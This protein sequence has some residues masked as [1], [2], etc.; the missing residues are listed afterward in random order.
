[1]MFRK[2][3]LYIFVFLASALVASLPIFGQSAY[4]Y[5]DGDADAIA[6]T[7]H[8]WSVTDAFMTGGSCTHSSQA[9]VW[10]YSP[11]GRSAYSIV[12]G[13]GAG[14]IARADAYLSTLNEQGS[15]EVDSRHNA[16][17]SCGGQFLNAAW[18]A[19]RW[20]SG[21]VITSSFVKVSEYGDG[22]ASYDKNCQSGI[23]YA[24]TCGGGN[25]RLAMPGYP[26]SFAHMPYY[27]ISIG[28]GGWFRCAGPGTPQF[29]SGPPRCSQAP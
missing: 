12:G 23:N 10:V 26:H 3:Q 6:S 17:C 19:R 16:W 22:T 20:F 13:P 2:R 7:L 21:G 4:Y 9:E 24:R 29:D 14:D 1:M 25:Y 18:A 28:T 11:T 8:S 27:F 5:N 15:F